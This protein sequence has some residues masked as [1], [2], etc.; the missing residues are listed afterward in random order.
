MA[1]HLITEGN[2]V[3]PCPFRLNVA[4]RIEKPFVLARII[5]I[6]SLCVGANC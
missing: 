5:G 1:R 3:Q 2:W 4:R 6:R